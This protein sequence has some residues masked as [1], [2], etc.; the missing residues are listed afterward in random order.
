[1]YTDDVAAVLRNAVSLLRPRGLLSVLT[2]NPGASAM[3]SGLQGRWSEAVQSLK[4]G[5]QLGPQYVPTC[6]PEIGTI[7]S[8]LA[9]LGLNEL[10]RYGVGVF[11]DHL[12]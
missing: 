3:R 12:V 11:S 10:A 4:A 9:E 2:L 7:T 1:M 6:A 8:C 5:R